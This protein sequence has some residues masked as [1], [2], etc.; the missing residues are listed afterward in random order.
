MYPPAVI[1]SPP[2]LITPQAPAGNGWGFL[3][4]R[5]DGS[6]TAAH[7]AS[8][9]DKLTRKGPKAGMKRF[10]PKLPF[11][12]AWNLVDRSQSIVQI[13]RRRQQASAKC[14]FAS[15]NNSLIDLGRM[16]DATTWTGCKCRSYS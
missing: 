6:G 8:H 4:Q 13:R 2:P 3:L 7:E 5:F 11:K 15:T 16:F 10:R 12:S 14:A 1:S 9:P